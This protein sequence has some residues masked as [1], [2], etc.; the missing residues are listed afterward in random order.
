MTKNHKD[1][2]TLIQSSL[3][4]VPNRF[5]ARSFFFRRSAT[6]E[7]IDLLMDHQVD[8]IEK[9]ISWKWCLLAISGRHFVLIM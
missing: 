7:P 9:Q 6:L 4:S 8:Y 5:Q 2:R 3:Y 1:D